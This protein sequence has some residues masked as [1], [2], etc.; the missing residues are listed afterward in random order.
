MAS[1]T[2]VENACAI[3]LASVCVGTAPIN[4]A[5]RVVEAS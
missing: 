1:A 2:P 3:S 5:K 4:S